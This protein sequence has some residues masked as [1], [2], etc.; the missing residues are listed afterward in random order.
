MPYC[1]IGESMTIS[2]PS[3]AS[4]ASARLMIERIFFSLQKEITLSIIAMPAI[5][6]AVGQEKRDTTAASVA[7]KTAPMAR[8]LSFF[9]SQVFDQVLK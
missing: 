3:I 2:A 8:P 5:A 4:K 9:S 1:N 7:K 6:I